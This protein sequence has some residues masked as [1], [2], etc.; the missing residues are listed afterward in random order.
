[1][2]KTKVISEASQK[3]RRREK[4]HCLQLE[5]RSSEGRQKGLAAGRKSPRRP[6]QG[7]ETAHVPR[8][9]PD[10]CQLKETLAR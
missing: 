5:G 1:M 8:P 2:A 3:G 9:V 4:H 6:H 7:R 10:P